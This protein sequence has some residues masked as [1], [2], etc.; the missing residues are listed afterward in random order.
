MNEKENYNSDNWINDV[1]RLI[2]RS[3]IQRKMRNSNSL[4][5]VIAQ[6]R[7]FENQ[8]RVREEVEK[9]IKEEFSL[10]EEMISAAT[11]LKRFL[12]T[13]VSKQNE[14]AIVILGSA[15]H[16]GAKIRSMMVENGEDHNDTSDLDFGILANNLDFLDEDFVNKADNF[17]KKNSQLHVC[18]TAS[19]ILLKSTNIKSV[20][21]AKNR[22][23]IMY[24]SKSAYEPEFIGLFFQPSIPPEVNQK[25]RK[26]IFEALHDIY[27]EDAEKWMDIF[28]VLLTFWKEMHNIKKNHL[29][30]KR[31]SLNKIDHDLIEKVVKNSG[32]IMSYPM[33][34]L[35][36]KKRMGQKSLFEK[37]RFFFTLK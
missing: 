26:L 3:T 28:I 1:L 31:N 29:S 13:E 7:A 15:I 24:K 34:E 25:N 22:L 17:L 12:D 2:R 30:Y 35:L 27:Q 10:D 16:G 21:D 18:E 36:T 4:R 33:T 11:K 6:T 20:E 8:N 14:F 37:I 5:D 9:L 32:K 19:P 23:E